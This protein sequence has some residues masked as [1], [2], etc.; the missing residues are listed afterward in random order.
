MVMLS[1]S[2]S[3]D[4]DDEDALTNTGGCDATLTIFPKLPSVAPCNGKA[5]TKKSLADQDKMIVKELKLNS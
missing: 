5:K 1:L 3:I 2:R 4:Q